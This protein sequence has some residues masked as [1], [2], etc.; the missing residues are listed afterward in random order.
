MQNSALN[1][2]FRVNQNVLTGGRVYKNLG[3]L[4][5]T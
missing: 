5:S 2:S 4:P 3:K 1:F